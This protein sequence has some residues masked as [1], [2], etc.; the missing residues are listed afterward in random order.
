MRFST[1]EFC[2][3][4]STAT[5]RAAGRGGAK[6]SDFSRDL[7]RR[8]PRSSLWGRSRALRQ[9]NS[10]PPEFDD[11]HVSN[12]HTRGE[13]TFTV[14]EPERGK[15]LLAV[16]NALAVAH[17]RPDLVTDLFGEILTEVNDWAGAVVLVLN[18]TSGRAW[19]LL[20]AAEANNG[21]TRKD[22]KHPIFVYPRHLVIAEKGR[23]DVVEPSQGLLE[24][25]RWLTERRR[26][27]RDRSRRF[28]Y[29]LVNDRR[30]AREQRRGDVDRDRNS[31]QDR[32]GL[33]CRR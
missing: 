24:F 1:T 25:L 4:Q 18:E 12:F 28:R 22:M 31:R 30:P 7:R 33:L 6:S 16:L 5:A 15:T 3:P 27:G 29:S 14:A 11:P 21:L 32:Q 10:D 17:E 26:E 20:R 9:Q 23:N 19:Q 8:D 2:R 13:V